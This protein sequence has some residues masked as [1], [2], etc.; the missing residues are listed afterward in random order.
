MFSTLFL[1]EIWFPAKNIWQCQEH[2]KMF[3]M[4]LYARESVADNCWY[5]LNRMLFRSFPILFRQTVIGLP[6][7]RKLFFI[8]P[9]MNVEGLSGTVVNMLSLIWVLSVTLHFFP[10]VKLDV[11]VRNEW[12]VPRWHFERS[13]KKIGCVQGFKRFYNQMVWSRRWLED[14]LTLRVQ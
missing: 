7:R 8:L 9:L 2:G 5:K 1:N 11:W 12:K 10:R 4:V 14:V 3:F 6:L 13:N